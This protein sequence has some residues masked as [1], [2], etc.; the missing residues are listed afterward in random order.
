MPS[1]G[2]CPAGPAALAQITEAKKICACCPVQTACLVSAMTT[3]Q[4]YGI[5]GG[6]TED[7]RRRL[8]RRE[9]REARRRLMYRCVPDS[10]LLPFYGRR[11]VHSADAN[12][13]RASSRAACS[14]AGVSPPSVR[15]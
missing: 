12:L 7:E 6:L 11:E 14:S 3:G 2:S 8:R 13:A 15:P 10:V 5:W 4:Q 9:S 1:C